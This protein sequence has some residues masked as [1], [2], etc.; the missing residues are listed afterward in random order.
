MPELWAALA[1]VVIWLVVLVVGVWEPD[2]VSN[3][4][5]VGVGESSTVPSV[6]VVVPFAFLATWVIARY[7]FVRVRQEYTTAPRPGAVAHPARTEALISS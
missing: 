6:I 5:V 3:N 4:S 2:L 7:D 1:I